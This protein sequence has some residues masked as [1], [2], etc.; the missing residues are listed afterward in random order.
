VFSTKLRQPYITL[1]LLPH[2]HE[3]LGG[4]IRAERGVPIAIGGVEDHVHLLLRWRTDETIANLMRK[5][6]SG[7]SL[8]VHQTFPECASFGWQDGYS[9][10]TVSRSLLEANRTYI[11][12]QAEHHRRRSFQEELLELLKRNEVEYDARYLWD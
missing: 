2:L 6:T 8:W 12:N 11:L 3:Y 10:F 9:A 7:S 1:A 4:V 5:I